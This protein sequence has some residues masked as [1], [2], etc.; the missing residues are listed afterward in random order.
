MGSRRV[1]WG[2]HQL[3]VLRDKYS[4]D[5]GG[6]GQSRNTESYTACCYLLEADTTMWRKN[7]ANHAGFQ[8]KKT[9]VKERGINTSWG[10]G[11]HMV[12]NC[13]RVEQRQ[14]WEYSPT[15]PSPSPLYPAFQHSSTI[16]FFGILP[17]SP[18]VL[19]NPQPALHY[20]SPNRLLC[21]CA[22]GHR[23]SLL[24]APSCI[25]FQRSHKQHC[26]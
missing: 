18:R 1:F 25:H 7:R 21:S 5:L 6:R 19:F 9:E 26:T 11:I 22:P 12:P 4:E 24:L 23:E 20:Y 16:N 15:T 14:P 2:A 13:K 8:L 17:F 3:T 10:P